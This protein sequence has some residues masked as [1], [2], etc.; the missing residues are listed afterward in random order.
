MICTAPGP[1]HHLTL[2]L[3]IDSDISYEVV[4]PASFFHFYEL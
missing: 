4:K 3:I 2:Y 1:T